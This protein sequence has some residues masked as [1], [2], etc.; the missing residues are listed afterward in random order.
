MTIETQVTRQAEA[1]AVTIEAHELWP[2]GTVRIEAWRLS[3]PTAE[4]EPRS[5]LTVQFGVRLL[6]SPFDEQIESLEFERVSGRCRD[7]VNAAG[8][9][10]TRINLHG[11]EGPGFEEKDGW[12]EVSWVSAYRLAVMSSGIRR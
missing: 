3:G 10:G 5:F 4:F 8:P 11:W 12:V 1:W 7:A 6:A 9:A 2:R